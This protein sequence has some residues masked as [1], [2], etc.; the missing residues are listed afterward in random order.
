MELKG[1][2]AI[3]KTRQIRGLNRAGA[4]RTAARN[5]LM[6]QRFDEELVI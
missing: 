4:P 2:D 3:V 1:F 6:L 5:T